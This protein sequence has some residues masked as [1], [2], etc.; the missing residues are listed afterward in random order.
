ME[1][2]HEDTNKLYIEICC[3]QNVWKQAPHPR[4]LQPVHTL[5]GNVVLATKRAGSVRGNRE[6][7]FKSPLCVSSLRAALLTALGSPAG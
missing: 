3:Y 2:T 4:P 5:A 1:K 7:A 6:K